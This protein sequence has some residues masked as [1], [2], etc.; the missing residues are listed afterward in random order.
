MSID[1][2]IVRKAGPEDAADVMGLC[3]LLADENAQF[4]MSEIK[5][6]H[7]LMA[8]LAPQLVQPG[9]IP[10]PAI[11]GVIGEPGGLKASIFLEVGCLWYTDEL[12]LHELWNFVHPDHRR[13][14][15]AKTLIE[16]AKACQQAIGLP[17][18]IGVISN[19]RTEAKVR[20][21]RR[22]LGEPAGAFF[23]YKANGKAM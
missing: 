9:Y 16:F 7:K 4:V 15:H 14:D 8:A 18:S 6:A 12:G 22:R 19:S 17:L 2:S 11:C 23:T 21:Y 13:S 20:L 3:R 5:V 10:M 1:L